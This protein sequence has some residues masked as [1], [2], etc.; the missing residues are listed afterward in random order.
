MI[1]EPIIT[2]L[3]SILGDTVMADPLLGGTAQIFALTLVLFFCLAVIL[4][5]FGFLVK[6]LKRRKNK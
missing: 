2:L 6:I 4:L 1:L 5:P 3:K